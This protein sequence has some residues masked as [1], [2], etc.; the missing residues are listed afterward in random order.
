MVKNVLGIL[1]LL[2]L[3][4]CANY[5]LNIAKEI[6]DD[7][8]IK[9]RPDGEIVHTMY[10]IGDSGNAKE[11]KATP[12]ALLL[13]KEHLDQADENSSVVFLGDNIYPNGMAPKR[14]VAERK[15]NVFRL[16]AQL[17]T[18]ANFKGEPYFIAGNHDWAKWGLD[19]VKR[20]EKYIEKT[21]DRGNVF[22]PDAGCGDPKEIEINENLVILAIDSEWFLQDWKGQTE[23]NDGCEVRNRFTFMKWFEEAL[24]SNR[25][26]NVVI[27]MHH[28]LFSNGPHG[29]GTTIKQHIFPLTQLKDE[30]YIPLPIIGTVGAFMRSLIGL[31]QDISHPNY[32]E[33]KKGLLA[34]ANKNGNFIFA[35][36][37]EHGMQYFEKSGHSFIVTGA[38][39]KKEPTALRDGAQFSYGQYGFTQLDFYEDGSVFMKFW[40]AYKDQPG[41]VVFEKRIKEALPSAGAE[42]PT[43]FPEFEKGEK[44]ITYPLTQKDFTKGKMGRALWGDHYRDAYKQSVTVPTVDLS[45]LNGGLRPIKRGG[46]YQTN[47]LRLEDANG[48]QYVMRSLDKDESRIVPYPFNESFVV[49]IFKDNF[50]AAHPMA[51]ITLADMADAAGVYHTNPQ[52]VYMAKQPALG[53]YNDLFGG[54][55]YL[56]EERPAKDRSD[57][58]SFGNSKKIIST[59]DMMEKITEKHGHR[60]DQAATVRSR[61]F[62]ILIG[63]WDRHDDQWRWA[64][65]K[66]GGETIYRPN[67]RD[68]DQVYSKYDGALFSILR[69]T[70]PF[71]KQLRKYDPKIPPNKIQWVNYHS[72][73]FD[74][75]FMTEADWEVWETAAKHIKENVTDEIIEA[76]IRKWPENVFAIDGEETIKVLKQRR[77]D[78]LLYAEGLYKYLAKKVDVHGTE[79]RDYF[80]VQRLDNERT[81]V[82]V[83]DTNKK[84]EKEAKLYDRIFKTSETQEISLYGYGSEDYFEVTGRVGEG[85]LVRAIGGLDEDTFMDDSFVVGPSQKT[86]VYDAKEEKSILKLGLEARVKISDRP[87]L[88]QYNHRAW[89]YEMDYT[90]PLLRLGG[91]FDDGILLGA[92]FTTTK[93]GFKKD[94]YASVQTFGGQV[95]AATGAFVLDYSGEWID[96]IGKWEFLL[97]VELRGPLYTRNFYDFGN[98]TVNRE[99]E[100]G[101]NYHRIRHRLYSVYPAIKKRFAGESGGFSIGPLLELSEV[102]RTEGRFID[103][104]GDQF[105]REVFDNQTFMGAKMDFNYLN[106]DVLG[107]PSRGIAFNTSLSYRANTNGNANDFVNVHSNL[108]LYQ[109]IGRPGRLTLATRVGINHNFTDQFEFYQGAV[110]GGIG[111]DANLRGFRRDRFTGQ[112]AFY[113]NTDLRLKLFNLKTK[114]LPMTMGIFGGFDYGRVWFAEEESD[115]WHTAIG[116]GIY[117][118]P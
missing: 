87:E 10:L 60:I 100:F 42:I 11:G 57:L 69:Y 98:E 45:T 91:N 38:G 28:P 99:A 48:H 25:N 88:N 21:L 59:Y 113:H 15:A 67:P 95:A 103:V 105:D 35:A 85:I 44:E 51:A 92:S 43:S 66:E 33:M 64:S 76:A 58:A 5:N 72:R 39:S 52:I 102:D 49:D 115:V 13:L 36:G 16:D 79:K 3:S 117:F 101:N 108:A 86:E 12:P 20:Q 114:A 61:L 17:N 55:L 75:T 89:D 97:D 73:H 104:I 19:G 4:S 62:D 37:H 118:A 109:N 9:V 71:M 31:R 50:S 80:L 30:L 81:R 23:I 70:I 54:G 68:R 83:F 94:P 74:R 2:C 56:F 26:K 40:A 46:G 90:M 107:L 82:M 96:A 110:L 116:G 112:T 27:A 6:E 1:A 65:F 47:S 14:E 53:E 34:G 63:D 93:Y 24:K 32:K 7:P 22:V 29:G 106:V 18:L 41:K 111:P 8:T 84:E 77:D 78:M